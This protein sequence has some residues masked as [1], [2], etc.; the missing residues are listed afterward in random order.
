[1]TGGRE[2][3]ERGWWKPRQETITY[4]ESPQ[5]PLQG[6][7]ANCPD[8]AA[9]QADPG[10]RAPIRACGGSDG[11]ESFASFQQNPQDHKPGLH[12]GLPGERGRV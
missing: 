7:S 11:N 9:V 8:L 12:V 4:L 10:L 3:Q 2:G 6:R 5:E 1:M